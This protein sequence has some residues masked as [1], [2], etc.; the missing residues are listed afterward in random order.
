MSDHEAEVHERLAI[1]ETETKNQSRDIEKVLEGIKE[2]AEG[3]GDFKIAHAER[4]AKVETKLK[5]YAGT[6]GIILPLIT[7][8]IVKFL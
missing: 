4:L 7:G 1:L 8:L 5:V 2:I 3:M 6:A